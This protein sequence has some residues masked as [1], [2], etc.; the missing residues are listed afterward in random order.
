MTEDDKLTDEEMRERDRQNAE[1]YRKVARDTVEWMEG[2]THP[3]MAP[4]SDCG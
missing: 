1:N 3:N 2:P 4:R